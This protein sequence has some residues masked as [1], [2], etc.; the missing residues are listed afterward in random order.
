MRDMRTLDHLQDGLDAEMGWRVKEISTFIMAAKTDGAEKKVYIRAG[1]ALMYA[2]WEG[3][4]KNSSE[5]YLNFVHHRG[6]TYRELKTCFAVFGLK[7]KLELLAAS[8]KS[9]P[10]IAAFDFIVSE[11]G[12]RAQM[13]MASAINT[14]SNLTSAVFS[15]I[16]ASLDIDLDRYS[17]KFNLIDE[18]LVARRNQVAHGEHVELKAQDFNDLAQE[19]LQL[20]RDYKV[21]VLNAASMKGY[22]REDRAA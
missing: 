12:E 20:M 5:M 17:T 8:R 16:A 1:I 9:G 15:N 10:N 14:G 21:D 2:H 6:L 13:K 22:L 11:L 7:G 3:F 18:S 19:V 4:V